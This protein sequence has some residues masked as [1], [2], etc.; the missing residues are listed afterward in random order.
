ME[1]EAAW[2]PEAERNNMPGNTDGSLT[3]IPGAS[4]HLRM[5]ERNSQIMIFLN[6][7]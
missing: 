4:Q 1:V 7:F 2:R 5:I 6:F 3:N